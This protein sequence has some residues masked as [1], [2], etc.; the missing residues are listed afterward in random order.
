MTQIWLVGHSLPNFDLDFVV[1]SK[2]EIIKQFPEVMLILLS[3]V[4]LG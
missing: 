2:G 1:E 3:S 4:V